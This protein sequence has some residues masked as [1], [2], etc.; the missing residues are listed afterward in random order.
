MGRFIPPGKLRL[1]QV[2][3]GSL[4]LTFG[5][6]EANVAVSLS[7]LGYP[8]AAALIVRDFPNLKKIAVTLRES[9]S[10]EI[11]EPDMFIEH[12]HEVF[13]PGAVINNRIIPHN[14]F[15]LF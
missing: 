13:I 1:R 11:A 7:N 3:P 9:V 12:G 2:M 15:A 6:A 10:A 14:G 4:D 8:E 5:G